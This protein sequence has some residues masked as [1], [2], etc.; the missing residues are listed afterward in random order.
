MEGGGSGGFRSGEP[1]RFPS[2]FSGSV[3]VMSLSHSW[4]FVFGASAVLCS[5]P[6]V[7]FAYCYSLQ[8]LELQAVV[9]RRQAARVYITVRTHR[10]QSNALQNRRVQSAKP[11]CT[12]CKRK[13]ILLL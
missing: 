5:R 11:A 6:T 8:N 9:R 1:G 10:V 3:I 7:L 13:G 4:R 2:K 12:C